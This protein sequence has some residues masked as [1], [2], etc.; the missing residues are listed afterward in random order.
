MRSR[1]DKFFLKAVLKLPQLLADALVEGGLVDRGLLMA[2]PRTEPEVLGLRC[3][4]PTAAGVG[5]D[6]GTAFS[7][8][9]GGIERVGCWG[10]LALPVVSMCGPASDGGEVSCLDVPVSTQIG[11][12][13]SGT[14]EGI[15]SMGGQ[16]RDD[17]SLCTARTPPGHLRKPTSTKIATACTRTTLQSSHHAS[18]H[19]TITST[20]TEPTRTKRSRVHLNEWS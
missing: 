20:P 16:Q 18:T 8:G 17:G 13:P 6:D 2:C 15:E 12:V 4:E 14:D 11:Y 19:T 3:A 5:P 10:I 1:V 9:T 7:G